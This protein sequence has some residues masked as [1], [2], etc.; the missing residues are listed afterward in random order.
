MIPSV[1]FVVSFSGCQK[2]KEELYGVREAE[3]LVYDEP[4]GL[5]RDSNSRISF[6]ATH[7]EEPFDATS[8]MEGMGLSKLVEKLRDDG[9]S[10]VD[11]YAQWDDHISTYNEEK[12]WI[13]LNCDDFGNFAAWL[14][15]E[16]D[17]YGTDSY[18]TIEC[19][20]F[21]SYSQF[22]LEEDPYYC[23]RP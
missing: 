21:G 18:T 7:C 15:N 17:D 10:S 14:I 6:L 3:H 23:Y 22:C 4:V 2:L 12:G 8:A 5:L 11:I 13:V 16:S 9:I 20:Y 1:F 19:Q